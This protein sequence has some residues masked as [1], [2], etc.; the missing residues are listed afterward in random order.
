[1]RRA[2][3]CVFKQA[4]KFPFEFIHF[5]PFVHVHA[6]FGVKIRMLTPVVPQIERRHVHNLPIA[7]RRVTDR[8]YESTRTSDELT[9]IRRRQQGSDR[10]NRQRQNHSDGE[11]NQ[12]KYDRA[13]KAQKLTKS[14]P[15]L[16]FVVIQFFVEFQHSPS[17]EFNVPKGH[18]IPLVNDPG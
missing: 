11:L 17:Q 12:G 18:R 8:Q 16:V 7:G 13:C 5:V 6:G 2:S 4:L 15:K 3:I 9:A 1:M 10:D 14:A